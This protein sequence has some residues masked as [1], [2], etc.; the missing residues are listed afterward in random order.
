MMKNVIKYL[1]LSLVGAAAFVA[2]NSAA[3]VDRGYYAI[4]GEVFFI[5]LPLF[6]YL[7]GQMARDI[8]QE[9]KIFMEEM[10]ND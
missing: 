3:T 5:L 1:F 9:I 10:K 8:K 6:W 2:A 4:G 7:F